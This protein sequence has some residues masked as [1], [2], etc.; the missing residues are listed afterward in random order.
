LTI[1]GTLATHNIK[2]EGDATKILEIRGDLTISGPNALDLDDANASTLDGKIILYGDWNNSGGTSAFLEGNST[3]EFIGTDV[4]YINTSDVS[5]DFS[6]LSVNNSS[7]E[8]LVLNDHVQTGGTL[9]LIG[10]LLNLNGF[11]LTINGAYT[12]N[13]GF[14]TGNAASDILVQGS[15][16]LAPFYF[17]D[18]QVLNSF[19]MNRTPGISVLATNL[20][21][22]YLTVTGGTVQLNAGKYFTVNTAINNTLASGLLLKSDASGTASLIHYDEGIPAISERYVEGGVWAYVFPPLSA[23]SEGIM[24]GVNPNFYWYNEPQYDYWTATTI[25]G[26]SGWTDVPAGALSTARGYIVYNP[27]TQVYNLTGGS[28]NYDAAGNKVFTANYTDS[29]DGA[30]NLNGVTADWDNFEGWNLFENPFSSA[31]DWDQTV[32]NNMDN[33]VYYYD[34]AAQNYKYYGSGTV[35]DIGI[36]VNGGSRYVPANQAF[37]VKATA[38]GGTLTIPNS[39]RVHNAT[40]YWKSLKTNPTNLIRMEIEKDGFIDETVIRSLSEAT[41]LHDGLYDA[42]KMFSFDKSKPMLFSRAWDNSY[43]WALNAIPIPKEHE[44]VPIG[45]YIG[46]SGDYTIRMTENSFEGMHVW[47]EDAFTKTEVNLREQSDYVFSQSLI[48]QSERFYLHLGVNRAPKLMIPLPDQETEA[49]VLYHYHLPEGLFIDED[50]GDKITINAD[51]TSGKALPEWLHFDA[52]TAEFQGTPFESQR[53][54]IRLTATD[55]FGAQAVESFVLDVKSFVDVDDITGSVSVYP[56]PAEEMITVTLSGFSQ[57]M[58]TMTDVNG[59]TVLQQSLNGE[60]TQ[61]DLSTMA[62]GIYFIKIISDRGTFN[63]KLM[64]R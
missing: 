48:E 54:E 3:V 25:Y 43:T 13:S 24:G 27:A 58:M 19:T 53:L 35:Y 28:L 16:T 8:G 31:I 7:T 51:L 29:G 1:T 46:Q 52:Y 20:T 63:Q 23:V 37:M 57:A 47:L 4:Q 50:F 36:T 44:I 49:G 62:K 12:R 6:N 45:V 26:T 15:G 55:I 33:M 17:S 64:V 14:F 34:G 61:I 60:K 41:Y 11:D 5:E 42:Y 38:N 40:A 10:G 18:P 2:I 22:N 9:S 30:V 21:M 56:N 59:K 39:A 32:K